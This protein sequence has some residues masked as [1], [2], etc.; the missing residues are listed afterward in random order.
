MSVRP[1]ELLE[2]AR[3]LAQGNREVDFR[4]AASRA[5]Y[6]AYHRGRQV[7]KSIGRLQ[8]SSRGVH[9]DV[10]DALYHPTNAKLKEIAQ[11]LARCR[12]LRVKADYKIGNSFKQS[13]AEACTRQ[14][15][16]ILALADQLEGNLATP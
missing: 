3:E 16:K 11:K 15:D 13:E 9:S 2:A 8:T 5:Y 4:N 1:N 6:A 14:A 12:S 7:A 10:I